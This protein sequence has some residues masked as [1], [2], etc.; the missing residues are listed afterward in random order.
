V[1]LGESLGIIK[2]IDIHPCLCHTG[3]FRF[4]L[5]TFIISTIEATIGKISSSRENRSG[6]L[7]QGRFQSIHVNEPNYLIH[8]SRYIHLNPVIAGLVDRP[9]KWEFS[10]YLEYAGLRSGTLPQTEYLRLQFQDEKTRE[11]L[12][13]DENLRSLLLDL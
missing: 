4:K 6:A 3:E 2:E 13:I 7:F 11:E 1:F 10:S 12:S 9:E 8:L 5:E